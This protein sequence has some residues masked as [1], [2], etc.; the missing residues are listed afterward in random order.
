MSITEMYFFLF[1]KIDEYF[2]YILEKKS[3]QNTAP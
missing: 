2:L 1:A 3:I